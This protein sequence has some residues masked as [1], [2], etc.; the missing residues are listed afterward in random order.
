ME[1]VSV[2]QVF[3]NLTRQLDVV[4]RKEL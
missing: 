4:P 3:E 1:A 2:E